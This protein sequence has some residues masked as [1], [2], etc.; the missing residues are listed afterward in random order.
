MPEWHPLRWVRSRS[1]D[2]LRELAAW[3]RNTL[4]SGHG[5]LHGLSYTLT[6]GVIEPETF[7]NF[8]DPWTIPLDSSSARILGLKATQ[9]IRYYPRRAFDLWGGC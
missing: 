7:L 3:Q 5:M 9:P 2:R 6:P 1:P 4:Q 8:F